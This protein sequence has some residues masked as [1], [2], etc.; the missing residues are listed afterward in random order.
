M[1]I[2]FLKEQEFGPLKLNNQQLRLIE[3]NRKK[4]IF[5][6]CIQLAE[7]QLYSGQWNG[8]SQTK[9]GYGLQ[10]WP[11]GSKYEG[12]WSHNMASGYGRFIL[13]DGDMYQGNWVNDKAHGEGNYYYA[14]GAMYNGKW[15]EDKQE[16]LGREEW[17]DGSFYEGE[18]LKGKKHGKG[19]F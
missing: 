5:Q 1:R 15:V 2:V 11:D 14:E 6:N 18:Y 10:V 4:L 9:E 3:E 12:L 8:N 19:T 16:G 7:G 13:A 17:P